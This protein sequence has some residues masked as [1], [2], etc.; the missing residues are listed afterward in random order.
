M[1]SWRQA[2][3]KYPELPEEPPISGGRRAMD[4]Y[5]GLTQNLRTALALF[6]PK[7][8]IY[9]RISGDTE[10]TGRR[11]S[12]EDLAQPKQVVIIL[13]VPAK[14]GLNSDTLLSMAIARLE[15]FLDERFA[16]AADRGRLQP[17]LLLLDET[18]RMRGFDPERFISFEREAQAGLVVV[19]QNLTQ[20]GEGSEGK[21]EV[22]KLLGVVGTQIY[23]RELRGKNYEYFKAQFPE[24]TRQ[25]YYVD[26]TPAPGGVVHN[27]RVQQEKV[28][29]LENIAL[30]ELPGGPY[31]A[32]V[33]LRGH[34][35]DKP[36][37]V[38]M[39]N[40]HFAA[41]AAEGQFLRAPVPAS[42]LKETIQ[43]LSR[44]DEIAKGVKNA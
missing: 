11:F 42:A 19:Y 21:H 24:V 32:L 27:R 18:R 13:E 30:A 25:T 10:G 41:A 37:L 22:D 36:F 35:A 15:G 20:I 38:D 16:E 9:S 4:T 31:S 5:E 44:A 40:K 29:F 7:R 14:G 1:A 43:V 3:A 33:Y 12:F 23:L 2:R 8:G 39:E 34:P 26:S 6:D 17:V 28:P